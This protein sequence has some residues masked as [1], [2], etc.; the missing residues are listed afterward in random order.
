MS[1]DKK[2]SDHRKLGQIIKGIHKHSPK[3]MAE[4]QIVSK[5]NTKKT[6]LQVDWRGR[7]RIISS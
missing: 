4:E 6:V 5:K 3:T 2:K 1:R 7:S